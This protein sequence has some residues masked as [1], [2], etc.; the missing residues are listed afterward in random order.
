[1]IASGQTI[2]SAMQ[3]I[4]QL[5]LLRANGLTYFRRDATGFWQSFTAAFISLPVIFLDLFLGSE[6]IPGSMSAAHFAINHILIYAINWLL[7]PLIIFYLLRFSNR[8]HL[9]FDFMVPYHWANLPI[10]MLIILIEFTLG[11][12]IFLLFGIIS[13]LWLVHAI[14]RFGLQLPI[15]LAIGFVLFSFTINMIIDS[16]LRGL[17]GI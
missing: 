8:G 15:P 17:G 13:A 7:F 3:G 4:F 11:T 1:M 5:A 2:R 12:P 10:T 6:N 16:Q 9:F 14:A